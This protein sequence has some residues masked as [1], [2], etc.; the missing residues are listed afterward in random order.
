[1]AIKFYL[2]D[3]QC[4]DQEQRIMSECG[5]LNIAPQL[6]LRGTLCFESDFR[7]DAMCHI[8]IIVMELQCK[9]LAQRFEEFEEHGASVG[10]I[11][12]HAMLAAQTAIELVFRLHSKCILHRDIK[13]ENMMYNVRIAFRC[14]HL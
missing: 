13:P 14:N 2:A 9:T 7:R 4:V 6:L 10:F 3:P 8:E 12:Q 5:C 1:V 11:L